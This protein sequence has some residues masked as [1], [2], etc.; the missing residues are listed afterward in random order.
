MI[1]SH[2]YH[3][4]CIKL[5]K[6][7]WESLLIAQNHFEHLT[8]WWNVR[9]LLS[10]FLSIRKVQCVLK[11]G[12][13]H[14]TQLY[15]EKHVCLNMIPCKRL[16]N[17]YFGLLHTLLNATPS[18]NSSMLGLKNPEQN[19]PPSTTHNTDYSHPDNAILCSVLDD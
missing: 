3:S 17:F 12:L 6:R 9:W 10:I 15:C 2:L 11:K 1:N 8:G 14:I 5:K 18:K 13:V 7:Y 16:S 19:T 4:L